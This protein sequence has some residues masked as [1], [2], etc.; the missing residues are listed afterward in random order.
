MREKP[1]S[2]AL[3]EFLERRVTLAKAIAR[4]GNAF[5]QLGLDPDASDVVGP[6]AGSVPDE[7]ASP[8]EA[9]DESA[10]LLGAVQAG[11]RFRDAAWAGSEMLRSDAAASRLN[12]SREGLN[13]QRRAG[14]VLGLAAK[15]P[16]FR[17][18]GTYRFDDP[19]CSFGTCSERGRP[20]SYGYGRIST[21]PS[22]PFTRI[23]CPSRIRR[24]AF[25]TPTTAGK[26]YSRAITAP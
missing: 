7:L 19:D 14:K 5:V 15:E 12:L 25:S 18:V 1:P 11:V 17:A 26:P 13:Q 8:D 4:R 22:V 16:G 23:R 6:Q 9:F 2:G 21:Y 24:V 10:T 20:V 3:R